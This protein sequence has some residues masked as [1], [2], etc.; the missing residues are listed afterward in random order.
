MAIRA[1]WATG[2]PSSRGRGGA[3]SRG[4]AMPGL[5]SPSAGAPPGGSGVPLLWTKLREA[6]RG[7]TG[8]AG[9]RLVGFPVGPQGGDPTPTPSALTAACT[10]WPSAQAHS[11]P[12]G[13]RPG[14][15]QAP[16]Q[17]PLSLN[18]ASPEPAP[19]TPPPARAAP[20]SGDAGPPQL[21]RGGAA[22]PSEP[23]MP[24][25]TRGKCPGPLAPT[26]WAPRLRKAARVRA[27]RLVPP[28]RPSSSA[29]PSQARAAA[30]YVRLRQGKGAGPGQ[31]WSSWP[32][33]PRPLGWQEGGREK[34]GGA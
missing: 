32:P 6:T 11:P 7:R 26:C 8:E 29:G 18:S 22:P 20:A 33:G 2:V 10:S 3:G 23:S 34:M 17:P 31:D 16:L 9:S 21:H 14:V 19:R 12:P 25:R 30:S 15:P 28:S 5:R 27:A 4:R 24:G 1:L 13:T